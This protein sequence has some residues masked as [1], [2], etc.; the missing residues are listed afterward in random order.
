MHRF[1]SLNTVSPHLPHL[2]LTSDEKT[3]TSSPHRG[4]FLIV[5]VGVRKCDVPGQ[6]PNND[7]SPSKRLGFRLQSVGYERKKG[8]LQSICMPAKAHKVPRRDCLRGQDRRAH[9]RARR[10][11][12][13]G[14]GPRLLPSVPKH[15][16]VYLCEVSPGSENADARLRSFFNGRRRSGVCRHGA[17]PARVCSQVLHRRGNYDLV[18]NNLPVFFIRDALKFPD[19][20]HSFK[21]A[22]DSNIPT[23]SSAN[24]RFWDFISLTPESTHMI[25][26]LFSD[27]G[28]PKSYR[29]LVSSWGKRIIDN[30]SSRAPHELAQE[31]TRR[32]GRYTP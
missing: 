29:P 12:E 11:R 22:P 30:V 17:R 23:S 2:T 19:M 16:P 15:G 28:T 20:V 10:T 7:I 14:G 3:S 13:R 4:H 21:P 31:T 8:A 24:S 32:R 9:P 1:M 27:R 26:W 6:L 18:R 5:S 25:T